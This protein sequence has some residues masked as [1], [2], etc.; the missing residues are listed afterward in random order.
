[1]Q[2]SG[3]GL[4]T[5]KDVHMS[6][7]PAPVN[8]GVH[9]VRMDLDG[10][11]SI[12]VSIRNVTPR[13]RRTSLKNGR[14]EVDTVEHLLAALSGL[15]IDNLIIEIDSEE[16]PGTDGSSLPFVEV[17][18]SSELVEQKAPKNLFTVSRPISV[19]KDDTTII[20]VPQKGALTIT[21]TLDYGSD[22]IS[23]QT[24]TYELDPESFAR[25]I[26]PSRTF[27]LASE[28]E[29]LQKLGL[30]K[31]ATYDNTLVVGP[32]G[33]IENS[34]RFRDE[35]VRHKILDIIGDL[36]LLNAG[37]E[38]HIIAHRSGHYLNMKL[39]NEIN[40]QMVKTL[41]SH[42]HEYLDIRAIQTIL[43]HR[44]PML[45]VDRVVEIEEDRR[46]VGIK[47]VTANEEF[48]RGHFPQQP[49]M[50]GVLI[51]E[52]MAQLAG[53]LLLRKLQN[54]GKLA[55]I[56][57]IDK[58]KLRKPVVPGDQLML[59]AEATRLRPRT[60]QVNTNATVDG[61]RVAEAQFKFMLVDA[62]SI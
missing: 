28:I 18:R 9:F 17:L 62:N 21:Y 38:G 26:A 55:V 13:L 35:Y 56:L 31:G 1:M 57:S 22:V 58:V 45:L 20:I 10:S 8:H 36:F 33:V 24:L 48:F 32:N 61:K 19:T 51:L 42:R 29:K 39:V 54:T 43:P 5:G 2:F 15:S 52:A 6:F 47:N 16:I 27:C 30:G 60:G 23:T 53:V 46:A 50:P 59:E 3:V 44:Y 4:F 14:A 7:K 25:E 37:V 49:I 11:P 40:D 34:L 12:D 41:F